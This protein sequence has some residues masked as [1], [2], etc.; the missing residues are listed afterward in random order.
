M[1]ARLRRVLAMLIIAVSRRSGHLGRLM[2]VRWIRRLLG[3]SGRRTAWRALGAQIDD[4]AAVSSGVWMRIPANVSL[5]AGSRLG[6]R[7]TIESYGP[8]SIGSN[9]IINDSDLFTTQHELDHPAFKAER[10]FITIGDYVWM[11]RKIIVLPGVTIGDYAVIGTG[12]VVTRD[13]P[14][15]AVAAGNPAEVLKERARIPYS[16]VPVNVAK[17]S[18]AIHRRQRSGKG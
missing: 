8:V 4:S 9:T 2:T 7:V 17:A 18:Q 6:G 10:L 15:Y 16:Y 14:P 11:P 3:P 5:G 1:S 13:I 12:S